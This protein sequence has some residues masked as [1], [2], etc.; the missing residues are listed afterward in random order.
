MMVI[1]NILYPFPSAESGEWTRSVQ[2]GL[3]TLDLLDMAE[4][5]FSDIGCYIGY[6][7][8]W[9]VVFFIAI[10]AS[11]IL[12]TISRGL[13]QPT[14]DGEEKTGF[15]SAVTIFNM[16]F[17]DGLFCFLRLYVMFTEGHVYFGLIFVIKEICSFIF[18][19]MLLCSKKNE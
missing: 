5:I 14:E 8:G 3:M 18:R 11:A 16:I 12:A 9:L 15:D 10:G 4:L 19:L 2:N 17:N 1:S 13:E 7:D 6:D